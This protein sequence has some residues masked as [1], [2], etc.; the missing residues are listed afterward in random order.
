[1][2]RKAAILLL[3]ILVAS[4]AF[5]QSSKLPSSRPTITGEQT[6]AT[7][8]TAINKVLG[9]QSFAI[10]LETYALALPLHDAILLCKEFLPKA[11]AAGKADLAAFSGSLALMAGRFAE[12][13]LLFSQGSTAVPASAGKEGVFSRPDLLLK[14]ARC[15]LA[16]GNYAEAKKQLD[17]VSDTLGEK[18]YREEKNIVLSWFFMLDGESEKAFM[19]LQ[20]LANGSDDA[21]IRRE[22]LFL[23]WLV[24]SLPD[25][26]DFT[27]ATDGLDARSLE[28]RL[29]AAY[30][31]SIEEAFSQKDILAKPAAWLLSGLY[32]WPIPQKTESWIAQEKASKIHD[33]DQGKGPA[34][35][36]VG[37][38]S[39][40][41]NASALAGKLNKLGFLVKTDEQKTSD[42]ELRWA[43]LVDATGDWSGTQAKLKDAGYESYLLP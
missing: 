18:S 17:K 38:F 25:F 16:A 40:K 36:Q 11:P 12:A 13:A 1:M 31:G 27:V 37:W 32:A 43:V 21:A 7:A 23:L 28:T 19:I 24:A 29:K 39:R 34:T 33:T 15:H 41:E 3:L 6:L 10:Y 20:P 4:Q 14:A 8:R 2:Y 35:L 26:A 30:P 5:A 9:G 42:G 22:A